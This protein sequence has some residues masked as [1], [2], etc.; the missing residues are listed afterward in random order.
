M[1]AKREQVPVTTRKGRVAIPER[2]RVFD[3]EEQFGV[4]ATDDAGVPYTSLISY[5]LTPDLKMAI[6][7][8]PKGTRKYTNILHSAQVSLLIDNRSKNENRLLKTEAVTIIGI[9]KHVRKGKAWQE[10]AEI[11]LRKHPDLEEFLNTPTT[12][13]IAVEIS[14]YIHVSRFQTLSVW[15]CK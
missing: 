7:A 2:L 6:F 15:D 1:G 14:R 11:F 8:T 10:F 5:A 9:A 13:L 3:A 12:A 4:L